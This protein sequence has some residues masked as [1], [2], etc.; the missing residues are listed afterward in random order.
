MLM[1][2]DIVAQYV[3][4]F[5]CLDNPRNWVMP[6]MEQFEQF[7]LPP[8]RLILSALGDVALSEPECRLIGHGGHADLVTLAPC[9]GLQPGDIDVRNAAPACVPNVFRLF[10]TEQ[11]CPGEGVEAICA[12]QYITSHLSPVHQASAHLCLILRNAYTCS[13]QLYFFCSKGFEK[14]C[15]EFCPVHDTTNRSQPFDEFVGSQISQYVAFP[16][17]DSPGRYCCTY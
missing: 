3:C 14:D 7:T 6:I 10:C 12:N 4:L 11:L 16:G 13:S 2:I 9:P 5:C 1:L 8:A 15:V 17:A